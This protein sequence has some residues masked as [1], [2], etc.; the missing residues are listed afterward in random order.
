MQLQDRA[1]HYNALHGKY[2]SAG[3]AKGNI[4]NPSL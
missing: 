4:S 1:L 3:V 2:S